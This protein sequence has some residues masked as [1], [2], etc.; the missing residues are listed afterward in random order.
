[1]RIS[2]KSFT[3]MFA[4]DYA[5]WEGVRPINILALRTFYFLMAAFVATDSWRVLI[6]H[7]GP[8]DHVRAVAFCVWA[9]YPTLAILGLIHPLRMLPIMFVTIGYKT[10]WLVFVAY[11][12]WRAGTLAGSPA[13]EMARVFAWTPLLVAVVPWKYVFD[14]YV[15]FPRRPTGASS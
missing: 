14:T 5:R 7:Q 10:L 13:E 9:T 6:T 3:S 11:P 1:M 2:L 12:L 4:R 8:W 15:R